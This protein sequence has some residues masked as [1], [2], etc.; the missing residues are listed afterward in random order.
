MEPID[1]A[2]ITA[3]EPPRAAPSPP[4]ASSTQP[5]SSTLPGPGSNQGILGQE[6]TGGERPSR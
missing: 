4:P 6:I 3:A 2:A 1:M 5:G